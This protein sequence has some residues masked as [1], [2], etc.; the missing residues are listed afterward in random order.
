MG[1][2]KRLTCNRIK[3]QYVYFSFPQWSSLN[4]LKSL[5]HHKLQ[6]YWYQ[7]YDPSNDRH[8][9]GSSNL[10]PLGRSLSP[11]IALKGY[12]AKDS[13]WI[14]FF[15]S[16]SYNESMVRHMASLV[17]TPPFANSSKLWENYLSAE[18]L[19]KLKEKRHKLCFFLKFESSLSVNVRWSCL[20]TE[21]EVIIGYGNTTSPPLS[22]NRMTDRHDSTHYLPTTSL[23]GRKNIIF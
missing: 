6:R 7:G 5:N 19:N 1:C 3:E 22:V 2:K 18:N 14:F 9:S 20:C 12:I 17:T 23:V 4:S 8:M 10:Q 11:L 16:S 21:V 13:D 15:T